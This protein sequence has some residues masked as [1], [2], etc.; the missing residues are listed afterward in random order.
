MESL[1]LFIMGETNSSLLST[2]D[3]SNL[4][5]IVIGIFAGLWAIWSVVTTPFSLRWLLISFSA[6]IL[7]GGGVRFG[8]QMNKRIS[9]VGV[10]AQIALGCGLFLVGWAILSLIN[11][12][13]TILT[14][15][16]I[17]GWGAISIINWVVVLQSILALSE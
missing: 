14:G 4:W 13:I 7:L 9:N 2:T 15:I 3:S 12:S 1:N 16:A 6:I 17:G 5:K 8:N 10:D 11:I